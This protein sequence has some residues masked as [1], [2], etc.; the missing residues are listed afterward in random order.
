MEGGDP[1]GTTSESALPTSG[2]CSPILGLD[3]SSAVL[4]IDLT[5][6]D[7]NLKF[8]LQPDGG[9]QSHNISNPKILVSPSGTF[10]SPSVLQHTSATSIV[11]PK[12]VLVSKEEAEMTKRYM[13]MHD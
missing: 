12:A 4:A 13:N 5:E 11:D 3:P 2:L 6:Q 10:M 7:C 8:A 9:A 1:P